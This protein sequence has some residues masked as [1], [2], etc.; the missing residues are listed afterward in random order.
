MT[1]LLPTLLLLLRG[2][3]VHQVVQRHTGDAF[4]HIMQNKRNTLQQLLGQ[5]P[6]AQPA[7]ARQLCHCA[8]DKRGLLNTH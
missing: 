3:Q 2:L 4:V 5:G 1:L 7:A 6:C 8:R